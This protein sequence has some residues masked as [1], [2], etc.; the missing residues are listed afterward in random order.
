VVDG[1]G[2]GGL[3]ALLAEPLGAALRLRARVSRIVF[4]AGA[5]RP[6]LEGGCGSDTLRARTQVLALPAAEAGALLAGLDPEAGR[7]AAALGYA[8]VA[9]VS[10]GLAAGATREPLRGFGFLVPRGEGEALLGCLF[11]SVLFPGRAP[12]GHALLTLLAGG[13]RRPEALAQPEDRLVAGLLAELDRAL[14]LRGE[15]T[16]VCVTRW[17]RAVP[18]PGREH[19]RRVTRV[20][21]R[22]ARLPRLVLAG[23]AWDGVAFGDALASGAAAAARLLAEEDVR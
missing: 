1:R 8:P 14:G 4:E 3:V 19:P 20:R 12:A 6:E 22:L 2:P 15:P 13:A 7:E 11:A 10:L 17:A 16:F 9:S 21:A 5:H 23:A 18:Q